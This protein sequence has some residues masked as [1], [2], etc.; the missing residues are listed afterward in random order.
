MPRRALVAPFWIEL[1]RAEYVLQVLPAMV[2]QLRV[3]ED[4]VDLDLG[5]VSAYVGFLEHLIKLGVRVYAVDDVAEDFLLALGAETVPRAEHQPF[6]I[7]SLFGHLHYLL[8]RRLR[9]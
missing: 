4:L 7:G 1:P 9:G 8:L 6:P 5:A 2:D 3:S